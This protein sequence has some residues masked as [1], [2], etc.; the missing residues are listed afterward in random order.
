MV[1]F[2]HRFLDVFRTN[3]KHEPEWL[4]IN[5]GAAYFTVNCY[6]CG[7][8]LFFDA[9]SVSLLFFEDTL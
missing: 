4:A 8:L 2:Y 6:W 3:N 1:E 5:L 9:M 7:N